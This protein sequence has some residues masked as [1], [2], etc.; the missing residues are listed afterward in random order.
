MEIDVFHFPRMARQR[1]LQLCRL[2]IPNLYGGVLARGRDHRKY[3]VKS[4]SCYRSP[5]AR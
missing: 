2:P 4:D 3:G 1:P 5:M